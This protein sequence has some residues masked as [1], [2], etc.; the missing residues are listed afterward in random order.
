MLEGAFSD[1]VESF[2]EEFAEKITDEFGDDSGKIACYFR[3]RYKVSSSVW[4][5]F[6]SGTKLTDYGQT[7]MDA[8]TEQVN[9]CLNEKDP[10]MVIVEILAVGKTKV[11]HKLT[12]E[13]KKNE[14]QTAS[15][16]P[17]K[18]S[19]GAKDIAGLGNALNGLSNALVQTNQLIFRGW[20]G[21]RSRTDALLIENTRLIQENLKL[22]YDIANK[23]WEAIAE[24][25]LKG[26]EHASPVA[27]QLIDALK[28]KWEKEAQAKAGQTV[29]VTP[30]AA[31]DAAFKELDDMLT[32]LEGIEKIGIVEK[33]EALQRATALLGAPRLARVQGIA[34]RL[35]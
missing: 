23:S 26:I 15:G 3:V 5:T 35:G 31:K 22:Q 2:F 24:T 33:I 25:A 1:D 10:A 34:K 19:G 17:E 14:I 21:E 9:N 16:K 12:I 28:S 32:W 8:V 18:L 27:I 7:D 30:E 29:E 20:S 11:I 4:N 13:N 6:S